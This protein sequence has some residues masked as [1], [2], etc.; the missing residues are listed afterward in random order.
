MN[1][2]FIR[3]TKGIECMRGPSIICVIILYSLIIFLIGCQGTNEIE[4]KQYE[5]KIEKTLYEISNLNTLDNEHR[6]RVIRYIY[7]LKYPLSPPP[8]NIT[9]SE[10]LES[11]KRLFL[12]PEFFQK[13]NIPEDKVEWKDFSVLLPSGDNKEKILKVFRASPTEQNP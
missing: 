13:F 3:G 11:L 2:I 1:Q 12:S 10:Y 7:L 8:Q 6:Y 9:P 4:Q 5:E